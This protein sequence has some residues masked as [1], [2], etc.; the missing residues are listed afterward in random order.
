VFFVLSKLLDVL[1]TPIVWAVILVALALPWRPSRPRNARRDLG[2]GIAGLAVLVL[3]SLAPVGNRLVRYLESSALDT[4]R[5]E[6]TYDAVVLLGGLVEDDVTAAHGTTAYNDHV[7]RLLVTYDLL[8]SG[9][10]RVAIVSGGP[11][12]GRGIVE[13]ER[14]RDQLVAWGIAPERV[15]VEPRATNTHENALFTA[16]IVKERGYSSLVIVTSAYHL[17]RAQGCFRAVGL[18]VDTKP[19][20]Y[21]AYDPAQST[22]SLVPRAAHLEASTRALRELFGR[23][24]Y[25]VIGYSKPA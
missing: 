20:D 9:R 13:A 12:G 19:A 16:A 4:T 5:P 2:F 11:V 8:R 21:R 18:T 10:A 3:F 17:A 6:V 25:R 24:V 7:E 14:L 1:V 15:L 23:L 22:G